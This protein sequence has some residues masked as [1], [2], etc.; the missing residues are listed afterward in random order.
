M[1]PVL[2]SPS[3]HDLPARSSPTGFCATALPVRM[4]VQLHK[5]LWGE[6]P[7]VL[8][9]RTEQASMNAVVLL[10][11]GLDSATVL[12]IAREPQATTAIACRV[13]YG[14]RHRA[15]LAAAARVAAGA[16]R[17]RHTA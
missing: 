7:G 2:F 16:G 6:K 10:S 17:G 3:H 8:S 1:C 15:E 12:A 9:W 11:G 13:D 5:Q 14:Q 4:Q